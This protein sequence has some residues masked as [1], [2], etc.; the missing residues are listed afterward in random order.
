MSHDCYWKT[1]YTQA[2]V[3]VKNSH[4]KVWRKKKNHVDLLANYVRR[5][6]FVR[7]ARFRTLPP[8][9]GAP[10]R[11]ASTH[12]PVVRIA[13]LMQIMIMQMWGRVASGPSWPQGLRKQSPLRDNNTIELCVLCI[14]QCNLTKIFASLFWKDFSFL[15]RAFTKVVEQMA[16]SQDLGVEAY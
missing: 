5:T 8:R 2:F 6:S 16:H 4:E 1:M 11:L 3:R 14:F 13:I 10:Y 12:V 15:S 7:G 9:P